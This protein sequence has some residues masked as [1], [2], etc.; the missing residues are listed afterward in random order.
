MAPLVEA[1]NSLAAQPLPP[2]GMSDED[3][4]EHENAMCYV[5]ELVCCNWLLRTPHAYAAD[6][7]VPAL[8]GGIWRH[9]LRASPAQ[10][11]R[12]VRLTEAVLEAAAA[13]AERAVVLE[14]LAIGL[15]PCAP[16]SS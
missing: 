14:S 1:V 8:L 6:D 12:C 15:L 4:D 16:A 10:L 9:S 5:V 13:D 2:Y 11:H 3:T 7:A